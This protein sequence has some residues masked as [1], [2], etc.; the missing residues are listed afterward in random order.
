MNDF[1]FFFWGEPL[2]LSMTLLT[3]DWIEFGLTNFIEKVSRFGEIIESCGG[4][5][6]L[7]TISL[8]NF[9]L[10]KNAESVINFYLKKKIN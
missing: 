10:F 7:S 9:H 6:H 5:C 1:F 3:C 2:R 8:K 4:P